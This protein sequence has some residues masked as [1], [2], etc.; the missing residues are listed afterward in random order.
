M[1][2]NS[3]RYNFKWTTSSF[4]ITTIVTMLLFPFLVINLGENKYGFL[5]FLT[6]INGLS[7]IA[8]FGLGDSSIKF[9]SESYLKQDFNK[10]YKIISN[11]T[12]LYFL[13][14]LTMLSL[15]YIFK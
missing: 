5:I 6:T 10:I 11:G 14:A 7:V 1:K 9:I 15:I 13:I 8:D 3:I 12:I 4:L 2:I